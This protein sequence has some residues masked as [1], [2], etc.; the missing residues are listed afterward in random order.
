MGSTNQPSKAKYNST[1]PLIVSG[2]QFI[3]VPES[4]IVCCPVLPAIACI[5]LG[6]V[7]PNAFTEKAVVNTVRLL[8]NRVGG[9]SYTLTNLIGNE[10]E[11][12]QYL[13]LES[14]HFM[15]SE[16]TFLEVMRKCGIPRYTMQLRQIAQ[17]AYIFY[18]DNEEAIDAELGISL[19]GCLRT[20]HQ[21]IKFDLEEILV[22]E[23][24]GLC[25]THSQGSERETQLLLAEE[26]AKTFQSRNVSPLAQATM[27]CFRESIIRNEEREDEEDAFD[28]IHR[29]IADSHLN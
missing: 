3:N 8:T 17:S 7:P 11:I 10:K 14:L 23:G 29:L 21:L 28:L 19:W 24:R 27:H 6:E 9:N 15:A 26:L 5:V 25:Q 18:R 2:D 1:M 22:G 20:F 13:T 4:T 16:S 12:E